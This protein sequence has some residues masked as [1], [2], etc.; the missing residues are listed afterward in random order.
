MKIFY[1]KCFLIIVFLPI[2]II[3]AFSITAKFTYT[4]QSNCAPAVV[5]FVNNSTTGTNITYTWN[6]GTGA[7][8]SVA[9]NSGQE[10]I[11]SK[12]GKYKV[13][14]VVSDG[15]HADTTSTIITIA[16]GPNVNFT[17]S[18]TIGCN[19]L[20]VHYTSTSTPGDTA[21]VNTIW[22]FRN[23]DYGSGTSVTY[24]YNQ[25]GKY[26]AFLKVTD[27]N[28]CYSH[29]EKDSLVQVVNKPT[30][31][32]VATDTF[33]CTP[34]LNVSFI[35][36]STGASDLTYKWNYGNGQSSAD[37]SNSSVYST[38]GNYNVTLKA[39]DL[40]GCS[41]SLV[42]TAYIRIGNPQG[43]LSVYDSNHK[44]V[45]K[46]TLCGGTYTFVF[47]IS[48][49]PDYTWTIN[50]NNNS[51]TISGR[52][53]ITYLVKD[54]GTLDINLMYGNGSNCTNNI[55]KT[56][57]KNYVKAG[58]TLNK[59]LFCSLP[60]K[61]T[62]RNTS[63][64]I[65]KCS[66]YFS[67]RFFSDKTDTS[68]TVTASDL[69]DKTY[70]Q[71]YSH[72]I[73]SL[74]KYFKLVVTSADGCMD[75]ITKETTI[76][77]PVARFM[78]DKVSGCIPLMVSLSDS[79]K[80][81][82]QIDANYY[83]IGTDSVAS[84]VKTPVVYTFTKPGEYYISEI[85]KSGGC[86]DTSSVVKIVAG[87]KLK[88]DFTVTPSEVC[89]QGKIHIEGTTDSNSVVH[90]WHFISP[91]IFDFTHYTSTPDTFITVNADT[92]G[93]KNISMQVDYNGCFSDTTKKNIFKIK[94]PVGNFVT[95]FACDSPL[96]YH[97][98]SDISPASSYVWNVDT[99]IYK[100]TDSVRYKFPL[101]G[102][103]TV[104]LVI[105]DSSTLCSLSLEKVV[106]VRQVKAAFTLNDTVFCAGDTAIL[107]SSISKDYVNTCYN[108]GFLWDFGDNSQPKRTFSITYNKV[109]SA[110]G[111]YNILLLAKADN[112]CTDSIKKTVHVYKPSGIF[113]TDTKSGC[114]PNLSV[115]FKNTSTDTTIVKWIWNFADGATDSTNKIAILHTYSSNIPTTYYPTLTVYDS[116]LCSGTYSLPITLIGINSDFQANDNAI[117]AG[118]TVTFTPVD[119]NLDSLYWNFGDKSSS[120]DS[121][122]TYNNRGQYTVTLI[123]SKDGC[124]DTVS[125]VNY[126]SVEN[127][128]ANF[129][130]S[131][132]V[133]NCYPDTLHFIHTNYNG[134][135][136]VDRVW[137]M[138]NQELTN[139]SDSVKY[140]Y[141]HSGN[142]TAQLSVKTL[143]GCKANSYKKIT[144]T[145]PSGTFSFSPQKI[146][147]NEVVNFQVSSLENVSSWKLLF[148]DGS[149]ST[150][151]P[152]NHRYTT[153]GK[154][155][156]ALLLMNNNCSIIKTADTL[157]VSMVKANF[158]CVGNIS[159]ICYGNN[160][161]FTN[162]SAYSE[163]WSWE[164]NNK[165]ISNDFN[166][167]DVSFSKIGDNYVTLIAS[168]ADNC[169]DTLIQSYTVVANPVFSIVGDSIMCKGQDSI[170]LSVN[171]DSGT[172][173]KWTPTTGLSNPSTFTTVAS[174]ISTITYMALVTD[175]NGCSTA[176]EKTIVINQPF[177]YSR[178]PL[179]D[180]T[181]HIGDKISLIILVGLSDI[182][183][184][185][186]PNYNIS[187]LN[188]YNPLVSPTRDVTYQVE[189]KNSCIDFIEDFTVKVIFDF[190]LEAPSAF[191]PNGDGTN[192]VF[193]LE[194]KNI[195][196]MELKIFD[197]WGKIVFTTNDVQNGWD[198]TVNG[199]IQN[200]DTYTYYI[201]AETIYGY[202]FEKKGSFLLL[203]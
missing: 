193:K 86:I 119:K 156:P 39:T 64:N 81:V 36:L 12:P 125:K 113:T 170:V 184:S 94:G 145:G 48:N 1:S 15:T 115:N 20:L 51:T 130:V 23:G 161:D 163:Y 148:G 100:N 127:A 7:D 134:S 58:F 180:T 99:A 14:L 144:I 46:P 187:C 13:V 8:V 116:L 57:T 90:S 95:S 164:L 34:P 202:K 111:T 30:V 71:L 61:V 138:D 167:S 159:K 53:S 181:I 59:S 162:T 82:F 137:T 143:D 169:T 87:A 123:A 154:I 89:N 192:D 191:T 149:T 96:I 196:S 147:R 73:D 105:V 112:G 41:D 189:L 21:I 65:G 103:Y 186:S 38:T 11:Y 107:N 22:D 165:L 33:A 120:A 66:W 63:T 32:F 106:K 158:N 101:S 146:C 10:Q 126:I 44:I 124:R 203:K 55:Q 175:A 9:D 121:T 198:G 194:E 199:H 135:S 6:F 40:Y 182:T 47:S 97:F 190:Y 142:Y 200:I 178:V 49:L 31:N 117:C 129:T 139:K 28:G 83:K 69:S 172:S 27:K 29:L 26:N 177:N 140:I 153:R 25:A 60:Q 56:F 185:W 72:E 102:N 201:T 19:P 78:P 4:K 75:S 132:S 76:S 188:C 88:P 35:N 114:L 3:S 80:S 141:T 166:L 77:L 155:V 174:P 79:S 151:N 128:D 136:V 45:T 157:S 43:T 37:I 54:T 150:D 16:R 92:S 70:Q 67:G 84:S 179:G 50:D 2:S 91:D 195:K 93:Y 133:L 109:Y 85:I 68:Y 160:A 171:K 152:V 5:E 122:H 118:Q 183:Y 18:P 24:T 108:E 173:I 42:K 17:A 110:K 98:K 104:K 74:Q 52:D 197:R 168:D 176:H 62:L 131:D